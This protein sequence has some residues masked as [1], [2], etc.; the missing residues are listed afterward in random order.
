MD[1]MA[2]QG[3]RRWW[4]GAA[5]VG[6]LVLLS[7]LV[8]AALVCYAMAWL[9]LHLL[10]WMWWNARGR[11][12][13][14]VYSDSPVWRAHIEQRFLP[15]LCQRAV[16]LNWSERNRWGLSLGRIAF[17]FF[18]GRREFNPL[19][20]IFRPF[21][22]TRTFRFWRPFHDMKHGRPEALRD[23]ECRFFESIGA[24]RPDLSDAG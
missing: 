14:F 15:Y 18:G 4:E 8:I 6:L 2:R 23:V 5:L 7:P 11:D 19:A 1:S 20:V 9:F 21:R 24:S 17:R 22:R 10:I 12:V 16:V 3:E 13:L